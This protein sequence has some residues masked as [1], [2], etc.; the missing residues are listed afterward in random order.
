MDYVASSCRL[1]AAKKDDDKGLMR[2]PN[3]FG[4]E[5]D[6]KTFKNILK[7]YLGNKKCFG[8]PLEYIMS[9]NDQPAGQAGIVYA[10]EHDFLYVTTPLEGEALRQNTVRCGKV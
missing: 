1:R 6:W 2:F 8:I 10:T 7:Y 5:T 3:S 9:N 4:K